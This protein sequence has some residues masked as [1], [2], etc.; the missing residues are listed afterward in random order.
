ME[1]CNDACDYNSTQYSA[2]PRQEDRTEQQ[3]GDAVQALNN[4]LKGLT[5]SDSS[6][7]LQNPALRDIVRE[8][9]RKYVH[10]DMLR[11]VDYTRQF[12]SDVKRTEYRNCVIKLI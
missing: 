6:G 5:I 1:D 12:D 8:A 10:N 3:V 2:H 9:E 7:G 11:R 4:L